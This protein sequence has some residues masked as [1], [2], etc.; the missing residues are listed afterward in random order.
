VTDGDQSY[1]VFTYQC[2]A[3]TWPG[4]ATIGFNAGGTLFQNHPLSGTTAASD[5][6]C[7][8]YSTTVWTNLIYR[9][10]PSGKNFINLMHPRNQCTNYT[11]LRHAFII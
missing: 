3:V 6:A 10:T 9:L 4:N 2:G 5:I 1:V 8:N 11:S 7:L